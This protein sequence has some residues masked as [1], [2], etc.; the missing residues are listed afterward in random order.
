MTS[1]QCLPGKEDSNTN[2][3][4]EQAKTV[5]GREILA[6]SLLIHLLAL[7]TTVA[8]VQLS[9]RNVY[10]YDEGAFPVGL[11][12]DDVLNLLQF[13]AKVHEILIVASVSSMTIHVVRRRLLG[14]GIPFGL[15]ISAYDVSP[16]L[17][18][19]KSLWANFKNLKDGMFVV[20]L[21]LVLL[22]VSA[23]GPSSAIALIPQ[24]D[25]WPIDNP[26]Y[27]KDVYI[28]LSQDEVYPMAFNNI[29]D[30]TSL[31][32]CSRQTQRQWCPNGAWEDIAN[33]AASY[34]WKSVASPNIS[35][36]DPFSRMRRQ[37]VSK[38]DNGTVS[39]TP[40]S[41]IVQALEL[42]WEHLNSTMEG[43]A[44]PMFSLG[45]SIFSPV[46]RVQCKTY[47][48]EDDEL[49]WPDGKPVNPIHYQDVEPA[50]LDSTLSEIEASIGF[51][52]VN[53]EPSLGAFIRA[54][55][56]L[57]GDQSVYL[58][59]CSVDARWSPA[60]VWLDPTNS[61]LVSTNLTDINLPSSSPIR[62]NTSWAKLLNLPR[63]PWRAD[64]FYLDSS[65]ATMMESLLLPFVS[66]PDDTATGIADFKAPYPE[67][68]ITSVVETILSMV[69]AEGLSRHTLNTVT[70]GL[71]HESGNG[72]IWT[73]LNNAFYLRTRKN[74]K[75]SLDL[76]SEGENWT[77]LGLEIYKFGWGY[78]L[79][80]RTVQF[81]IVV[82]CL[83]LSTLVIYVIYS[84]WYCI[85]GGLRS[86]AW[87][88][89]GE[90]MALATR[91]NLGD[92]GAGV[93]K[94]ETWMTVVQVRAIADD[95]L[96]LVTNGG[97]EVELGKKYR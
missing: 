13:V 71:V 45:G 70:S 24:L 50:Y 65:N 27:M 20:G 5:L 22:F 19:S 90:M 10:W 52:W 76:S 55:R 66:T 73:N 92:V 38:I 39:S 86:G 60:E 16:K 75:H 2:R 69:V 17:L 93:K 53:L 95:K 51:A 59:P 74:Y 30:T 28:D 40:H 14:K 88:D 78:S 68:T 4:G 46:V 61:N 85:R 1:H 67:T 94:A 25:W 42:L 11:P 31:T 23:V 97:V 79:E 37:L 9:F 33:W 63:F 18:F 49:Q 29:T 12:E 82:L 57:D 3:T 26:S 87:S 91:K 83:Y 72:D 44:R 84:S 62:I 36:T 80:S 35:M 96:E 15:L 6:P 34:S 43:V 48:Y 58:F 77:R 32:E 8:V 64:G 81:G 47:D 54:P 89:M 21:I 56:N 7:G 41:G